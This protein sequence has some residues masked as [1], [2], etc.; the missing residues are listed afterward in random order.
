MI[1][2]IVWIANCFLAIMIAI[3]TIW[4]PSMQAKT[5]TNIKADPFDGTVMP[6][7]YVPNWLKADLR[8]KTLDFRNISSSDLVP[9]PKYDVSA[10]LDQNNI[11]GRFTYPVMY[12]GSYTLIIKNTTEVI[13]GLI[14]VRRLGRSFEYCEWCRSANG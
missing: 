3:T 5:Y 7:S 12:M 10:L 11:M 4:L 13:W 6:I 2:A 9:I 8:N 14:C 1:L